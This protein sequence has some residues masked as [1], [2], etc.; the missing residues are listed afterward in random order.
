MTKEQLTTSM[1]MLFRRFQE[2]G[3]LVVYGSKAEG[4]LFLGA[5]PA[6]RI[7]GSDQKPENRELRSEDDVRAWVS[8]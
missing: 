5:A 6:E 2:Q 1:L 4:R 8:S 3:I 7:R